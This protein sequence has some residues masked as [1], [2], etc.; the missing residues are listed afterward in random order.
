MIY[1]SHVNEDSRV[2][3]ALM[4]ENNFSHIVAV[5]GSG[6]RVLALM[7]HESL[8]DIVAVDL[9]NDAIHLLQLKICMLINSEA[10]EYLKFIGHLETEKDHR[11]NRFEKIKGQLS[12]ACREYWEQRIHLIEKGILN[13]GHFEIFLKKVRPLLNVFLGK[14]F[15]KRSSQEKKSKWIAFKWKIVSW[16]FSRRWVYLLMGNKDMAFISKDASVKQIPSV[17]TKQINE[18][19]ASASFITHLIFNGHLRDMKQSDLPLS[20]QEKHLNTIRERLKTGQLVIKY[21]ESDL[22]EH[23][24]RTENVSGERTFYS[25][26]DILSFEDHEYLDK[27]INSCL[28]SPGDQVIFRSFL[29]NRLSPLELQQLTASYH[30]VKILDAK[31]ST[32]MYQV[33]AIES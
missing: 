3:R 22:L 16:F 23:V 12:V 31:D 11:V 6:E 19:S 15:M 26:S 2:E 10:D 32:G 25:V 27:L 30:E 5:A 9:N 13:A 14:D 20:L 8:S 18:G 1:Y 29:R 17:L 21:H 33:I 4:Q 28:K 7:D 24:R